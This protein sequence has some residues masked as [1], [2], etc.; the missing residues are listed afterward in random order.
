MLQQIDFGWTYNCGHRTYDGRRPESRL[1][2]GACLH[3]DG[4]LPRGVLFDALQVK[5]IPPGSAFSL[6][7]GSAFS[8]DG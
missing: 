2:I 5:D 1:V 4:R 7:P 3:L 8:A 6:S